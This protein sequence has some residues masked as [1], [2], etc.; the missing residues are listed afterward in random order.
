MCQD[1][2]TAIVIGKK[3]QEV[4]TGYSD[5]EALSK[6]IFNAY[7]Q[8]NLRYS[9]NAPLNLYD[10]QNTATNLPAQ[11]ELY[12]VQGDEYHFL[13]LAK[14]GGS[15]NKTNL[16][17]ETKVVLSP[18]TLLD[19][20]TD[21]MKSLGTAACPPYH[22]AFVIG[23]TSAELN[24]KTVKLATARYLDGLPTQGS[25]SGHAFRDLEL[26]ARLLEISREL[27]IGAQF[28]GRYF[29]LDTR[30]IRLPRHGASC[31]IGLGVSCS[32][33]RNIK[34]QITTEGIFLEQLE[35]DPSKYLPES[36]AADE[37]AVRIDL[38]QPM[39]NIRAIL[40]RYPVATRLFLNGKIIVARDIAH[41]RLNER[42]KRGE[43][44]PD[45]LKDH[46]IYYA[47]PAKTPEGYP[48]GSFGPTTAGRMDPYVPI[49]QKQHVSLIMLA[50]GNRSKTV[51]DS[52]KKYGGFYLGSIGGP[53]ARLGEECITNVEVL[54]YPELGMEAIFMITV[55]DFPAFIIVDDK[56]NDF[57]ESLL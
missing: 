41:A 20:M 18:D 29:C 19:F 12:A 36:Q 48:S 46:I 38:N 13:F 50:K 39:K 17:Q 22:L 23:G 35:T 51:T 28:G 33:D 10:E 53:A 8:G 2:G 24:L 30:V 40:S 52:C 42:L 54:E 16:F 47:G 6:G 44:L 34:A 31:P 21:K 55:K 57:F 15:A 1:T 5:E 26:E 9:Q 25:A 11:I 4:W 7:T 37:D 14:G 49:F 27:A 43:N 32:A 45:Y 56:G 3:G